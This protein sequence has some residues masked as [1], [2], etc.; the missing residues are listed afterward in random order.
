MLSPSRHYQQDTTLVRRAEVEKALLTVDYFDSSV[1]RIIRNDLF[2]L[3]GSYCVAGHVTQ[4]RRVPVKFDILGA[5]PEV[6]RTCRY[7]RHGRQKNQ[8]T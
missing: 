2:R 4:I 1:E 3:F 5:T 7:R 8:A 6:Y